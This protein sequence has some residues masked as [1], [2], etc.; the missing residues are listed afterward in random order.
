MRGFRGGQDHPL[1]SLM[2]HLVFNPATLRFKALVA[3]VCV[4]GLKCLLCCCCVLLP[5]LCG[6]G[7]VFDVLL[8]GPRARE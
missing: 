2:T 7:G 8:S 1:T 4:W 3:E 5:H 6:S